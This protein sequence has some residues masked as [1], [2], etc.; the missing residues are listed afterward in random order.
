MTRFTI[1]RSVRRVGGGRVLIGGSPLKVLTLTAAGAHIFDRI[2]A[3]DD[4][5]ATA[6]QRGFIDRFVDAGIVHP[7]PARLAAPVA[8]TIV[9]P[10]CAASDSVLA[11]LVAACH[12]SGAASATAAPT[13]DVSVIVADV[14]IVDDASPIPVGRVEG[15]T[16]IR[17]AHNRGPGA[18]RMTGLGNVV[19]PFVAFV[20]TDVVPDDGWLTRLVGHFADDR[21][22]LVAPRVAAA[23][24]ASVLDRYESLHSPLDLGDQPAQVMAGTGVGYVPSAAIVVRT[25]ALRSIGG[26]DPSMR[27]GEDVDLVWR[28]TNAGHRVRYEPA[29]HV[30]HSSR[31]TWSAWTRQRVGYGSSAAPLA[32]RHPG[33]LAPVR[34]SGWSAAAWAMAV[35]GRPLAGAAVAGGTTAALAY[36][37]RAVPDGRRQ[38]VRLAGLGNL[39]AGRALASAVTRA[40]WPLAI[41]GSLVS[42]RI[43]RASAIAAIAPP[44]IDWLVKQPPIDPLRYVTI[45]VADDLSYGVGVIRGVIDEH[46]T[47]ALQP[48][49]SSW[50]N[51]PRAGRPRVDR[52]RPDRQPSANAG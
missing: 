16:V 8:V 28:L 48:D 12:R 7:A 24:G 5:I 36:K 20:D 37:L 49:F 11:D 43:R 39:F 30:H 47:A 25:A 21:V 6:A 26:F 1:D 33:A 29:S 32:R 38:A 17:H 45:R 41:A 52:P 4:L 40:W 46:S 19:T 3:G 9:I 10:A 51:R 42:K 44:L 22:A 15:A 2:V 34:V 18:A 13:A 14:I 23:G 35:L 50:P 27:V 31:P